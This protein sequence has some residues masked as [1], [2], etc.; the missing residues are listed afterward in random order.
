M[1]GMVTGEC[2]DRQRKSYIIKTNCKHSK[3]RYGRLPLGNIY[4]CRGIF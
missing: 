4:T 2:E 1:G 3:G